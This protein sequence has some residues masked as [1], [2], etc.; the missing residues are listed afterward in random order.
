MATRAKA[1]SRKG[2]RE[3][4]ASSAKKGARETATKASTSARASRAP[5][6]PKPPKWPWI[7]ARRIRLL[8]L[9]ERAE[10]LV[11]DL[12]F[13]LLGGPSGSRPDAGFRDGSPQGIAAWMRWEFLRSANAQRGVLAAAREWVSLALRA[14]DCFVWV[15]RIAESEAEEQTARAA[16]AAFDEALRAQG[17]RRIAEVLEHV[18][19]RQP[20]LP[21]LSSIEH[22]GPRDVLARLRQWIDAVPEVDEPLRSEVLA[23]L[24]DFLSPAGSVHERSTARRSSSSARCEIAASASWYRIGE[25]KK[26]EVRAP[27]LRKVLVEL[28]RAEGAVL[29]SQVLADR[30]GLPSKRANIPALFETGRTK[31]RHELLD[32]IVCKRSSG[33]PRSECLW[34]IPRREGLEIKPD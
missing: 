27:A 21:L 2:A 19:S 10:P 3:E 26:Q 29:Q 22:D 28:I 14:R 25:A 31:R 4:A 5:K 33:G 7:E 32:S 8:G 30:A 17:L 6:P 24:F 20:M 1:G 34:S 11:R 18:R 9:D 16:C 12:A 13:R 15:E 23:K